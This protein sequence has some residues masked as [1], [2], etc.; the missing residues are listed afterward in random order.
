[1]ARRTFSSNWHL[2]A[3]RQAA[4][5]VR[6]GLLQDQEEK[7][8]SG[9]AKGGQPFAGIWGVPK[10]HFFFFCLPP[11]AAKGILQRPCS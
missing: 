5:F 2:Q 1:M 6:P 3:N 8:S 4:F 9:I 7:M 10:S 11:Q